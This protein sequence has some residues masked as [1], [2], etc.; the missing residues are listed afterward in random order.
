MGPSTVHRSPPAD[1]QKVRRSVAITPHRNTQQPGNARVEN[2][3]RSHV[4]R[5]P[6]NTGKPIYERQVRG[7][8]LNSMERQDFLVA[9]DSL[10]Q[11]MAKGDLECP[12]TLLA[13]ARLLN[14]LADRLGMVVIDDQ[15]NLTPEYYSV[16]PSVRG[17]MLS[18]QH[19]K[20]EFESALLC[21]HRSD[22]HQAARMADGLL[23]VVHNFLTAFPDAA[24][25]LE[26]LY[27]AKALSLISSI[28]AR[29]VEKGV[30][31]PD[32]MADRF[33]V[34]AGMHDDLWALQTNPVRVSD[35][36][37]AVIAAQMPARVPNADFG[38]R[39]QA[40]AS[41]Q[42][43][44]RRGMDL[45]GSERLLPDVSSVIAS[46]LQAGSVPL[47]DHLRAVALTNRRNYEAWS[48]TPV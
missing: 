7:G 1:R 18:L 12:T 35:I 48:G 16:A 45:G 25:P 28:Y 46:H 29:C 23:T 13:V 37:R 44:I 34:W 33:R 19:I 31:D 24:G 14:P 40:A 2:D 27:S 42:R 41:A 9:S 10:Q 11:I 15:R 38:T 3:L 26:L 30:G 32:D 22:L 17:L 6:K 47:H 5:R 21:D 8:C 43:L 4:V 39:F 36:N 20:V